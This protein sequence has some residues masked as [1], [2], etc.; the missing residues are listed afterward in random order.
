M[1]SIPSVAQQYR[2]AARRSGKDQMLLS[3]SNVPA[4]SCQGSIQMLLL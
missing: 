4:I 2:P 3:G 1:L